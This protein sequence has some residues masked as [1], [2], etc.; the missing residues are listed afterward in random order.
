MLP[1]LKVIVIVIILILTKSNC[2]CNHYICFQEVIGIVMITLVS[3]YKSGVNCLNNLRADDN[4][5][6]VYGGEQCQKYS[7]DYGV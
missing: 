5:V 4:G 3:N 6:W 7:V 1:I 2:N